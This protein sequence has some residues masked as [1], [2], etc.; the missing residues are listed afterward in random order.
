MRRT[1]VYFPEE[2]L[3]LLKKEAKEKNTTMAAVLREKVDK[4]IKKPTKKEIEEAMK[5]VEE[6][7]K[8]NLPTMPPAKMKKIFAEAH[9]PHL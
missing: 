9:D 4:E 1:Q 8:L 5:A 6:I 2:T 7:S 3:E